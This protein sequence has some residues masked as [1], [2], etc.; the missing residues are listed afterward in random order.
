MIASHL[1]YPQ[2]AIAVGVSQEAVHDR[3]RA[4]RCEPVD[5]FGK[6]MLRWRDVRTWQKEREKRARAIL[7]STPR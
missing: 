7:K 5:V 3:I 1:T 4:K 2:V 6:P